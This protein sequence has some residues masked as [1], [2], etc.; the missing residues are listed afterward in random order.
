MWMFAWPKIS[1]SI[2]AWSEPKPKTKMLWHSFHGLRGIGP[3]K[4]CFFKNRS[5]SNYL[6]A[7]IQEQWKLSFLNLRGVFP[8]VRKFD[9]EM[10]CYGNLALRQMHTL[11]VPNTV[12]MSKDALKGKTLLLAVIFWKSVL[13]KTSTL[14]SNFSSLCQ[15]VAL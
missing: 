13:K 10:R 9:L 4:K 3:L 12:R 2:L 5:V 7:W 1:L 15:Y 8:H 11:L 6:N 14:P